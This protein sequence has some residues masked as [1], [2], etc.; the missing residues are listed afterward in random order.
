M[1]VRR[2]REDIQV[3][4]QYTSFTTCTFI[5]FCTPFGRKR[6]LVM[7]ILEKPWVFIFQTIYDTLGSS[8]NSL[9][10]IISHYLDIVENWFAGYFQ[11]FPHLNEFWN[12]PFYFQTMP[13]IMWRAGLFFAHK[14]NLFNCDISN[15]LNF[16][17]GLQWH[18]TY[19][20]PL[21]AAQS[22]HSLSR[23]LSR[24][25]SCAVFVTE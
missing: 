5:M 18:F 4:L 2:V 9:D 15:N 17:R 25:C 16:F 8:C 14:K 21:L 22:W 19:T 20:Y 13:R 3:L 23:R 6:S 12:P 24:G 7:V 10:E 1:W 11:F